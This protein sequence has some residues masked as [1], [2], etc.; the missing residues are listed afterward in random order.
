[1]KVIQ[2]RLWLS[3]ITIIVALLLL[4]M[5]IIHEEFLLA[6]IAVFATLAGLVSLFLG[7]QYRESAKLII[8]N[9]LLD[10]C[11]VTISAGNSNSNSV[12]QPVECVLSPFGLLI[13]GK[14]Y[15]FGRD[16]I[17]LHSMDI[18]VSQI[19]VGF[20]SDKNKCSAVLLVDPLDAD[21]I[22]KITERMICEAGITPRIS[23]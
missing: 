15:K 18:G 4:L 13:G 1:M 11:P 12:R 22:A 8:E 9:R 3:G 21:Q 19:T 6:V 14:V 7:L 20:G 10:I 23:I 5:F 17:R 2:R 16:G